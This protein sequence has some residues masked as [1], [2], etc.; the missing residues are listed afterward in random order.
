[1]PP[2][3]RGHGEVRVCPRDTC[4]ASDAAGA[5]PN[6]PI[7]VRNLPNLITLGRV[8][9]VPVVVW[10]L[11]TGQVQW[12]FFGFLLAGLSDAVDGYLVKRF[13]WHSALGAYLDPLADKLLLVSIFVTLG[14]L[15]ELP[16]WFVIAVVSRDILIVLAVLLS[17]LMGNPI[18]MKPF[19]ISKANTAAQI[20]LVLLVLADEGFQLGLERTRLV[21]MW[22]TALFTVA[23]LLAYMRAWLRHMG[24]YESAPGSGSII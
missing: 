9:L 3:R 7:A 17:W 15:A 19:A 10:L 22:T 23:S 14:L 11:L 18:V 2:R 8:I 6:I 24:L 20:I 16:S 13:G 5:R 4:G 1:M 21:V 12:A